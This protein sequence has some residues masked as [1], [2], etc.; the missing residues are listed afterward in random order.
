MQVKRVKIVTGYGDVQ[1]ISSYLS[2][3]EGIKTTDASIRLALNFSTNS[4]L[5]IKIRKIA[6]EEFNMTIKEEIIEA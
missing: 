5:S 1:R 6:L 4:D 2:E 3:K